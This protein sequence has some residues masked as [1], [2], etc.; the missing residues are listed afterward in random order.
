MLRQVSLRNFKCYAA[1]SIPFGGLTVLSGANGVGKSTVGQA[2]LLLRQQLLMQQGGQVGAGAVLNGPLVK[3]GGA[4]DVIPSF[5]TGHDDQTVSISLD[6]DDGRV[7]FELERKDL[8]D[9]GEG[10]DLAVKSAVVSSPLFAGDSLVYLSSDRMGPR[11][12]YPVPGL[13]DG[14][15]RYGNRGEFAVYWLHRAAA[16]PL[17]NA[18]LAERVGTPDDRSLVGCLCDCIDPIHAGTRLR[19]QLFADAEQV[20][21]SYSFWNGQVWSRDYRA[22][23]VGYGLTCVLPVYI[24]LLRARPGEVLIIENPEIHLHPKGQ[25]AVGRFVAQVAATGVQVVLETHSDHVLNGIRLA[26]KERQISHDQVVLHFVTNDDSSSGARIVT[27]RILPSGR[28][29]FWPAGFFDE[30]ETV[31]MKLF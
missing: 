10:R 17:D 16:K 25:T 29:D 5:L 26:V 13:G 21:L 8:Q 30:Y 12:S 9:G 11:M 24:A 6:C 14:V 22:V 28:V 4:L 19:T 2:I 31:Q 20:S 1:A 23:N 27:P 7:A 3:L 18:A 15:N